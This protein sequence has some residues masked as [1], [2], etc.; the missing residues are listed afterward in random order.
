M[1]CAARARRA[2]TVYHSKLQ[3]QV[4]GQVPLPSL[5]ITR[6]SDSAPLVLLHEGA[7][8]K[9]PKN[10]S[11]TVQNSTKCIT[12]LSILNPPPRPRATR[13]RSSVNFARSVSCMPRTADTYR[14]SISIPCP[15]VS[16]TARPITIVH[17]VFKRRSPR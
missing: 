1:R 11:P 5:T 14:W 3:H 16:L 12:V 8:R 9:S 10:L 7:Q 17:A 15:D 4:F 13:A 2:L 6:P